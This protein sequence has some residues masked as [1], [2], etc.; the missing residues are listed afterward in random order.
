[1][2]AKPKLKLKSGGGSA[3][4]AAVLQPKTIYASDPESKPKRKGHI[5]KNKVGL[6]C[7]SALSLCWM[8]V[9]TFAAPP[10]G[11]NSGKD[12]ELCVGTPTEGKLCLCPR[13]TV[14]ATK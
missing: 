4:A 12:G 14:C 8:L 1:M 9:T 7:I 2:N 6:L 13:E 3:K 10:L 11:A 5:N